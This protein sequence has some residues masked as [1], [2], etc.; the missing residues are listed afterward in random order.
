MFIILGCICVFLVLFASSGS[1]LTTKQIVAHAKVEALA[2]NAQTL[3]IS[4]SEQI[5]LLNSIVDKMADDPEV[6]TAVEQKNPELMNSQ[7]QELSTHAPGIHSIKL[8]L[9]D[10]KTPSGIQNNDLSFGDIDLATRT[11]TKNQTS[12]IQ[13]DNDNERYL[14]IAR[15]IVKSNKVI[16]II[17]VG[18]DYS[19]INRF[20]ST[21]K[22]DN[23][24]LE[25]RQG[26]L[27]LAATDTKEE[28]AEFDDDPV[29]VPETNWQV[30]F[31]PTG[32]VTI[33]ESSIMSGM[34][35]IPAAI[36]ILS[37]LIVYRLL[38]G[39]LNQDLAWILKAFKD[40]LT[41]KPLGEYPVKLAETRGL[42]STITQFKRVVN[43]KWFEI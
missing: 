33:L 10:E 3:A 18:F 19:F 16:G 29:A 31:R 2:T 21:I 25:L 8:I 43:D 11:F 15:R 1:F 37:F 42:I 28:Q 17:L 13:G 4:L 32:Q 5:K 35:V 38:H 41:E 6:I 23:G 9:P 39:I 40:L 22:I 26:K 7:I 30:F 12:F 20:V 34:V 24:Y 27:T 14:A 36:L